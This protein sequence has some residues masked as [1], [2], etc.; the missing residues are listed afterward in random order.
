MNHLSLNEIEAGMENILASPKD[1]GE[2]QLITIRPR[3]NERI[4]LK[5]ATLDEKLGLTGDVWAE[6]DGN[7]DTQIAIMNS[8]AIALVAGQPD[9]WKL[10]GDQLYIDL[11]IS[12]SNLPAGT[13]FKLGSAV[14]EITS[15]PNTGCGKFVERFGKDAM[16][17]YNSKFGRELN[18]RGTYAKVVQ[19]GTIAVGDRAEKIVDIDEQR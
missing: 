16:K 10:A 9:R 19:T 18:L 17:F 2:L 8:R 13:R 11:D 3:E 12:V 5:T 1:M 7:L 6:E 4:E 15:E 14:L